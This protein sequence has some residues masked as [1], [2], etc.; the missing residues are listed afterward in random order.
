MTYKSDGKLMGFGHLKKN[1]CMKKNSGKKEKERENENE[2]E[3]L[4]V[5]GTCCISRWLE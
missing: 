5:V 3:Q 2:N 1:L 4:F